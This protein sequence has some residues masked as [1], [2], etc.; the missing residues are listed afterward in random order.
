MIDFH[1]HSSA[2]DGALNPKELLE[3]AAREGV[4]RFALTDHDTINGYLTVKDRVPEGLRLVSGV[5]LSC[6]WARIGIHVVGL[7]FD[8]DAPSLRQ[9]LQLLDAARLVRATRIG[10]RLESA[11]M[12]GALRGAQSVAS[13]AQI[14]RPHFARW[15]VMAGHVDSEEAA[16]KRFLGRGKPG[17]IS[18]LWPSLEAT[19]AAIKQAGGLSVL[20]HPLEYKMTATKLRALTVAFAEAGGD[21]MELINGRPRPGDIAALWRLI[22]D[23]QLAV[24]VGSDFHRDTPYGAGLGVVPSDIPAG[25]GVWER[26]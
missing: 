15:M 18:V 9:H 16:F 11:G 23:R 20:A 4:T 5:E 6:Q 2:S 8:P 1:T 12:T 19:T 25:R 17:D 21:A 10:E 3:R 22:E 24:S 14:G 7:G 26:L 13:G